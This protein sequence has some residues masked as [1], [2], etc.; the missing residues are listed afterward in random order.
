MLK[1]Y[2][3]GDTLCVSVNLFMERKTKTDGEMSREVLK[4]STRKIVAAKIA[5]VE[6]ALPVKRRVRKIGAKKSGKVDELRELAQRYEA[7]MQTCFNAMNTDSI[8]KEFNISCSVTLGSVPGTVLCYA[9][10]CKRDVLIYRIEGYVLSY[11]RD[12]KEMACMLYQEMM[13]R[14]LIVAEVLGI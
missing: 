13:A 12:V 6:S 1:A 2:I 7:V 5:E 8:Y 9:K 10:L 4:K 11:P 3:T 14:G